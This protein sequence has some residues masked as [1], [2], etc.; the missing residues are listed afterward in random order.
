MD[1]TPLLTG[2]VL[3]EGGLNDGEA[4]K[5]ATVTM[6]GNVAKLAHYEP[7]KGR[8]VELDRLT[9]MRVDEKANGQFVITG[10]SQQLVGEVGLSP[11]EAKVTW[12]VTP[13]GCATC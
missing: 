4:V 11:D 1:S 5:R 6:N 2:S 12:R 7:S 8:S 10:I 9:D 3:I 13:K